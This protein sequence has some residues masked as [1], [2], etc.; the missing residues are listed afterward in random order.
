MA[1]KRGGSRRRRRYVK[2]S[3]DHKLELSTLAGSTVIGSQNTDS[4]EENSWLSSVKAAW[5]LNDVTIADSVGPVLVGFAHSDYTDTE[6][7]EWIENGNSWSEGNLV[8][9]E[10]AKRKIRQV[11]VFN[12]RA[13]AATSSWMTL[14]DGRMITTKAGFL[15]FS[16]DSLR[17][18]AYNMGAS[19]FSTTSPELRVQ[20]HANLW[21]Q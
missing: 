10:I 11:G 16:D 13:G 7:E 3:I 19:A 20:G 15:L 4:V 12:T 6:I 8:G 1:R 14:E 17:W 9:Q 21:P 18:W 2:G 5:S